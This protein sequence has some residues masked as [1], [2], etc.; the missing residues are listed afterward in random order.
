MNFWVVWW[1]FTKFLMWY[2]K[3]RVGSLFSVIKDNSYTLF[4]WNLIW[5]WQKEPTKLQN[6]GL[7]TAQV[8]FHLVCTLIESFCWKYIKFQLKRCV[9]QNVKKNRFVVSKMTRLWW[10]LIRALKSLGKLLFDWSLLC[11]VCNVWPKKD[12]FMTLKSYAK[13]NCCLENEMNNWENFHL[14]TWKSQNSTLMG[15]ICPE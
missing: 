6:F 4:S 3:P 5:F 14:S 9:M 1:K 15:F 10:I 11:K 2:L 8:E 13:L 7:S 12:I